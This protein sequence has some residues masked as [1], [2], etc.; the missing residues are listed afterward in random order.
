[1]GQHGNG[2]IPANLP[3]EFKLMGKKVLVV[4]DELLDILAGDGSIDPG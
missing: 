1:M 4:I 3:L 2:R